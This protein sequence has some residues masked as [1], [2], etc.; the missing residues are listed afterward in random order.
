MR[1][2]DTL[3]GIRCMLEILGVYTLEILVIGDCVT[4]R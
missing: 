3:E 1:I 4:L 2:G